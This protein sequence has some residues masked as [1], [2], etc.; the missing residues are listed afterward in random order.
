MIWGN[1]HRVLGARTKVSDK[2]G[3]QAIQATVATL[4]IIVNSEVKRPNKVIFR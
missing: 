1:V 3:R 2:G 4:G